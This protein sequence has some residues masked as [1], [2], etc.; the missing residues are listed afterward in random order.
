VIRLSALLILLCIGQAR[1]DVGAGPPGSGFDTRLAAEVYATALAFMAPRTLDPV[2]VS[3]LTV[4]G[5]RGLTA[6]DPTLIAAWQD[7]RLRLGRQSGWLF[8]MVAPRDE[9]PRS[10]AAAAATLAEAAVAASQAVRRAGTQGVVQSFFD[11]VFNHLDPY[12]RYEAPTAAR[13]DRAQR[14]GSAGIGLTL[15]GARGATIVRGVVGESPAALAGLRAGDAILS[16]DG[17]S[18]RGRDPAAVARWLA[19]PE[20]ST[21]IIEWRGHDRRIRRQELTRMLVP[22]DTVFA[23]RVGGVLFIRLTGFNYATDTQLSRALQDGVS[24]PRAPDGVVLD[25]RGNRGGLLRQAVTAADTLLPQGVVAY[26]AGRDPAAARVWRSEAG[27]LAGE[28]PVVVIVDGRTASAAEVLA[29]ALADRGRAVVV[30]SATLGK[31]LVQTIAPLPD[32]GELFVTWSRIL[33]PRQWPL[34]GLGVL[35]QVCTS[36][37][38]EAL[39]RQ[40]D[41]LARGVQPMQPAITASRAA[42]APLTPARTL[43][44]RAPCPAAEGRERD[45]EA[46]RVLLENPAAYAAALLSPVTPSGQSVGLSDGR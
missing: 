36:L 3:Q 14:Q 41:A 9:E 44:L 28:R 29:A 25:L 33:A 26:T 34:Q 35:P 7:G 13:E 31:G 16:V 11:E 12:S 23:Q 5:L 18:T 43:A 38:S 15:G 19:G 30:G 21:L 1:A 20:G 32:G 8:E 27:E 45:L 24:G 39:R 2:P 42:R 10:W 6:I 37:G 17:Q 46:A 4:W 40:L 22:P